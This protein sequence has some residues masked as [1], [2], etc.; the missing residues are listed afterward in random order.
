MLNTHVVSLIVLLIIVV[1]ILGIVIMHAHCSCKESSGVQH[2]GF[3]DRWSKNIENQARIHSYKEVSSVPI[4]LL[5]SLNVYS[6]DQMAH[7]SGVTYIFWTGGFDSTFRVL[8][9]IINEGK[10]VQP[11]YL[12]D[13]IDNDPSKY[14]RK[15]LEHELNAMEK[16]RKQFLYDYPQHTL[17]FLPVIIVRDLV[18][19]PQVSQ[20]TKKL[21]ER[22]M[23]RRPVCQ[24]GAIAQYSLDLGKPIDLAVEYEPTS[25]MMYTAIHDKVIGDETTRRID[26][27]LF[28]QQQEL[29]IYENFRF[30][31]LHLS[32]KG[33]LEK[34]KASKFDVYLED[35]WSC[36]YP[37]DGNPCG[38]CV[39]CKERIM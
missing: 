25:S 31:T 26:P 10:I 11:V 36:W 23:L 4:Q 32:K 8:D 14:H 1:F 12:A 37:V 18:I 34:A 20:A 21:H 28:H 29:K 3:Q 13:I 6:T 39:M 24:Y 33:M 9:A 19:S 16:I 17:R 35:T 5:D 2:E 7:S 38:R 30:P 27:A 15:S 22:K